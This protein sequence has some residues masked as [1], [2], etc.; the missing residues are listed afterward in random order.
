MVVVGGGAANEIAGGAVGGG[1]EPLV[2][3]VE[4]AGEAGGRRRKIDEQVGRV[5][6]EA[7][8][9]CGL[10]GWQGAQVNF[11]RHSQH[12]DLARRTIE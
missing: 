9:Q 1:V 3:Q 2:E 8:I 4:P 7:V 11:A 10:Q 12:D 6:I 5:P